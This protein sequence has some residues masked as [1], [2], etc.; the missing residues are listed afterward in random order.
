[1]VNE[2]EKA[3][4]E[5]EYAELT[6]QAD[7]LERRYSRTS[8]FRIISFLAAVAL[9]LIGISDQVMVAG[10]AG[11]LFLL[12]FVWLVTVHA[13]IVRDTTLVKSKTQVVDRY[14]KRFDDGWREFASDGSEYLEQQDTVAMDVDLIG[15]NSLF[16]MIN[17][18]HTG[19]GEKMLA[20]TMKLSTFDRT[21]TE[22]NREAVAEL[23][24]E[25]TFAI[26]FEAAGMRL[27]GRK[28]NFNREAFEQTCRS[29]E[30]SGLPKWAK[31]V[32]VGLPLIE[33]MLLVLWITGVL[34]YGYPL[35]GFVIVL[36]FSW[37]TKSVTDAVIQPLY[38]IAYVVEDYIDMMAELSKMRFQSDMLKNIQQ[39]VAGEHGTLAAFRALRSISQAYNVSFNP[40][41]HQ[42]LSGLLL[43]DYQLAGIVMR[44]K[45]K[46]GDSV[47]GCF[48]NLGQVEVL[49]S[50][51]V[52]GHVRKTGWGEI[53][54][55]LE[56]E[57]HLSCE[58]IYHP[59]ITPDK[60]QENSVKLQSGITVITGSNM[61]GKTTFLRTIAMNLALTYMGAPICGKSLSANYMR[62]FTSMRITDDVA[63]GIST[64]YAEILR[65]KTM[66]EYRK[67]GQPMLCLIDEIFKGT[68]S[69]DRI[70]GAKE[71]LTGLSGEKCIT[72]VSTHDFE[73]CSI[74]D[75]ENNPA[76]NYHFEEYY[77][78]DELKFDYKIKSGR[79][80]TTNARAILRMAGFDVAD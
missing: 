41:L 22:K 69:S 54:N 14:L 71:V 9:L 4:F 38:G 66:A 60:V 30:E 65:I 27:A 43:W 37:L 45:K 51:A 70:V 64:F 55:S 79:C 7:E 39:N 18:C 31:I 10:I 42:L 56:G 32:R 80:T 28:K 35:A 12:I 34:H 24:H 73:L 61:S 58:D 53:D 8:T 48:E 16:Q 17:V 33:I 2:E 19:C 49:L 52:I 67:T 72:L 20:E 25:R 78:G 3:Q 26:N 62:M 74:A 47:A 46:Y 59:L 13:D 50:L 75:K 68:N 5:Q 40:L 6:K 1:M 76:V 57:C 36:S 15:A 11:A 23:M 77:E 29:D 44:W 21:A 63:H